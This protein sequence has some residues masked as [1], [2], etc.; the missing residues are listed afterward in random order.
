[1]GLEPGSHLPRGSLQTHE[2]LWHF[3][4]G[5]GSLLPRTA[6]AHVHQA[7]LC[8]ASPSLS[9]SRWAGTCLYGPA[10]P[11]FMWRLWPGLS[12]ASLGSRG[13]ATPS[14]CIS[15]AAT[16]H[17][18]A[19]PSRAAPRRAPLPALRWWGQGED[20]EGEE[21]LSGA[22]HPCTESSPHLVVG[23]G[24]VRK[25]GGCSAPDAVLLWGL[26]IN[27]LPFPLD[28]GINCLNILQIRH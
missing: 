11:D 24:G 2:S 6:T 17:V 7:R 10:W 14:G 27:P 1:M 12:G 22:K 26:G 20:K 4:T 25:K 19:G 15:V 16:P 8:S 23:G 5:P 9:C 18:Q 13:R 21:S 3:L 28:V